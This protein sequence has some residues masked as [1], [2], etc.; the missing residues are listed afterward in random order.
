MISSIHNDE[1]NRYIEK[2]DL[3]LTKIRFYRE[4]AWRQSNEDEKENNLGLV[5]F[6]FF[7]WLMYVCMSCDT[8]VYLMKI[9]KTMTTYNQHGTFQLVRVGGETYILFKV[10]VQAL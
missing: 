3:N 2:L 6:L 10:V 4:A 9:S 5:V 1:L 7:L 8:D